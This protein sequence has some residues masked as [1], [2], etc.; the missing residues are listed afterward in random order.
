MLSLASP[1][2]KQDREVVLEA[3]KQDRT[4]INFAHLVLQIDEELML[5][6]K[7]SVKNL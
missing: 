2:L 7:N 5:L 3:I 4:A 1:R 6:V